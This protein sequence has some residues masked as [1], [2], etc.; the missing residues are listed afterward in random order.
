MTT[1]P[2]RA[3]TVTWSIEVSGADPEA[4]VRE[5]IETMRSPEP[6][7]VD[8]FEVYDVQAHT[9]VE[10]DMA[11][12]TSRPIPYWPRV[13]VVVD[14]DHAGTEVHVF[15]QGTKAEPDN[16]AGPAAWHILDPGSEDDNPDHAWY[17][18]AITHPDDTP[19]PVQQFINRLAMDNHQCGNEEDCA[20]ADAEG[21]ITVEA[22]A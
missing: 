4:A 18:Q 2:S 5:A 11:S 19:L 10:I 21:V 16:L 6:Q 3:Y 7:P 1:E 14:H 15:V 17:R 8:C 20:A 13:D 22:R 9:A 12:G